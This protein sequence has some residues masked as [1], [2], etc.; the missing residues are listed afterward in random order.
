MINVLFCY[1]RTA[2]VNGQ[3]QGRVWEKPFSMGDS[4]ASENFVSETSSSFIP[5]LD[6]EK[7]IELALK[8]KEASADIQ[9]VTQKLK[10]LGL[11]R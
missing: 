5:M 11:E 1:A 7:E 9:E 6:V 10:E 4:I 8:S 3:R 2:Y